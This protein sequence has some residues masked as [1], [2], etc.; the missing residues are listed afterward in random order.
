ML[1]SSASCFIKLI[2]CI[3]E[4]FRSE[5]QNLEMCFNGGSICNTKLP[6]EEI[7]SSDL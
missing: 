6:E 2:P 1:S 3:I 7:R 4:P 5:D